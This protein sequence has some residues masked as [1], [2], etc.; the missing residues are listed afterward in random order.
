MTNDAIKYNDSK[1]WLTKKSHSIGGSEISAILG[2]NPYMTA[3][4]VYLNKVEGKQI[5]NKIV[6]R[7]GTV[8]E[9][10][11]AELFA[12][13][14]GY[15]VIMPSQR[16]F[17]HKEYDYLVGS[18]DRFFTKE[19]TAGVLECKTTSISYDDIPDFWQLQNQWYMGIIGSDFGSVAFL[20]NNR[21]F[22]FREFDLNKELFEAM[23]YAAVSF[24]NNHVLKQN[25][26]EITDKNISEVSKIYKSHID[27]LKIK[28]SQ[29]TVSLLN[30]Y[31]AVKNIKKIVEA[32]EEELK[33]KI[34][35]ILK[36]SEALIN[37]NDDVLATWKKNKDSKTFDTDLF[38]AENPEL[39]SKYLKDKQGAR[40]LLTKDKNLTPDLSQDG[41][42]KIVNEKLLIT[43]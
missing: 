23:V 42:I 36:D 37:E 20:K 21:E 19:N 34:K 11:V 6:M 24:W 4:D 26:P 5:E 33:D 15:K 30:S 27:G 25:P 39:Y 14:T 2:L 31:V 29:E 7:A 41:L 43:Q 16:L 35:F 28:A 13:E 1:E 12:E 8:L 9:P 38:K 32:K 10:F 3:I 18:P 40:P 22:G 17:V